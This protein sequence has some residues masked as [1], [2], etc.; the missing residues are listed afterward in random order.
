MLITTF[1]KY[2]SEPPVF[3]LHRSS[4]LKKRYRS[5][6]SDQY[7]GSRKL[8]WPKIKRGDPSHKKIFFFYFDIFMGIN[9]TVPM[10]WFQNCMKFCCATPLSGDIGKNMPKNAKIANFIIF[11]TFWTVFLK[12]SPLREVA[13]QNFIQFWN[14]CISTVELIPIKMSKSKK[15]FFARRVPPFDFLAKIICNFLNTGPI[16]RI[17]TFF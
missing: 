5:W 6:K 2:H 12:I 7:W 9:L 8:F 1:L 10:H 16:F 4:W 14:Q 13:Q 3:L 17:Y 15:Y 11:S